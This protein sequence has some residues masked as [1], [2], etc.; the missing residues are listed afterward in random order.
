MNSEEIKKILEGILSRMSVSWN[1]IEFF[2][3]GEDGIG[4][5]LVKTNEPEILIGREGV[6]LLAINHLVRKMTDRNADEAEA[7]F[8]VDVNDYQKKKLEDLKQKARMMA[9][10]AR[11]FKSSVELEPMSSYERMIVHSFLAP[12]ADVSTESIGQG[13]TRHIVIRYKEVS[14]I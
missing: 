11:F 6:T 13:P 5:F 7:S 4:R 8:M 1:S 3:G 10:R 9:E 12:Y 2:A 14:G